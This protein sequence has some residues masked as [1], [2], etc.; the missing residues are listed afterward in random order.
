MISLSEGI[1][2][3]LNCT[4]WCILYP[5]LLQE[6]PPSSKQLHACKQPF[7]ISPKSTDSARIYTRRSN[8]HSSRLRMLQRHARRP[9]ALHKL[10]GCCV[11]LLAVGVVVGD[12]EDNRRHPDQRRPVGVGEGNGQS[13]GEARPDDD[14]GAVEEAEGV[15]VDA[16]GA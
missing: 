6:L 3:E 7:Q 2:K 12:C 9:V 15:D 8:S 10:D 1:V 5:L 11:S 4:R 14:E 16:V 13:G